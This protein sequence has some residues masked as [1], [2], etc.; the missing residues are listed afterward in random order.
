LS[1]RNPAAYLPFGIGA[2]KCLGMKMAL[3]QIKLFIVRLLQNYTINLASNKNKSVSS[4]CP[5]SIKLSETI[6][7]KDVFFCGPVNNIEVS[8]S[9]RKQTTILKAENIYSLNE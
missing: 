7:T 3:S 8:I 1:E 9:K 4:S 2:R 5:N 6:E